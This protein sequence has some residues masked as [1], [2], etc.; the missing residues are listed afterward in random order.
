MTKELSHLTFL[1]QSLTI[2]LGTYDNI[3]MSSALQ[4]WMP[5]CL[6]VTTDIT[7]LNILTKVLFV[8]WLLGGSKQLLV[9]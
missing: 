2:I 9:K 1:S 5:L 6:C 7:K 4:D 8:A 3:R